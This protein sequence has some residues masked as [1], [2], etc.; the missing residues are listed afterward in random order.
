M[1]LALHGRRYSYQATGEVVQHIFQP[2]IQLKA[3]DPIPVLNIFR[4]DRFF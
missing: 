2:R 4:L 3:L 1:A